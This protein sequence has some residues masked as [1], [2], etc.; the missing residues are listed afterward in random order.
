M[1]IVWTVKN[2]DSTIAHLAEVKAIVRAEAT[3]GFDRAKAKKAA[4]VRDPGNRGP[5]SRVTL[6]HGKLDWFVNLEDPGGAA[7]AI[8]FGSR[9]RPGK[10]YI[11]GVW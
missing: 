11:T 1:A 3:A 6:T 5:H 4:D 7:G 10:H 9:G 2:V 8:E